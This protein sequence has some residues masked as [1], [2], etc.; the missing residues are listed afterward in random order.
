MANHVDRSTRASTGVRYNG[1]DIPVAVL[2]ERRMQLMLHA[3][4]RV[5]RGS[6]G[7]QGLS[8]ACL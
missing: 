6:A 2:A 5:S 3:G 1:K 8:R 4:D 7:Q